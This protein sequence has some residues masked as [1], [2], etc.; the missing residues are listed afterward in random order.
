[1]AFGIQE[2]ERHLLECDARAQ[3]L[4]GDFYRAWRRL[5]EQELTEL[6]FAACRETETA[7]LIECGAHRAEASV[8]FAEEDPDRAALAFEANPHT[9][10]KQ[11]IFAASPQ[12]T[13][14]NEGVGAEPAV[15]CL[16]IP[17]KHGTGSRTSTMASFLPEKQSRAY[18]TAEVPVTTVDHAVE[19]FS[20]SP[21]F[22]LWIDVEGYGAEVLAGAAAS[23]NE[24]VAVVLIEASNGSK[25]VGETAADG[26]IELLRSHG[27]RE[28]A[29]DCSKSNN[30]QFNLLFV[31]EEAPWLEQ[32]IE[33]FFRRIERPIARSVYQRLFTVHAQLRKR[34]NGLR[35]RVS[36]SIRDFRKGR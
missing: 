33:R 7:S 17:D 12:V 10:R 28:V 30:S 23:L 1:M 2:F 4:G 14:V 13:P 34:N 22:A 5:T 27:L 21:P 26:I 16:R 8:R 25:W 9:F 32:E 20:M 18:S 29:R 35:R 6:F 3:A 31:R 24:D 15:L 19:K 11:T 36:R